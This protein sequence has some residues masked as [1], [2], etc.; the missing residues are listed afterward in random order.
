MAKYIRKFLGPIIRSVKDYPPHYTTKKAHLTIAKG[1]LELDF[2]KAWP[3]W[4]NVSYQSSTTA[5]S[6]L[7]LKRQFSYVNFKYEIVGEYPFLGKGP[8]YPQIPLF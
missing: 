3:S 1:I 6:I 4:K 2:Q 7:L 5:A 8:V